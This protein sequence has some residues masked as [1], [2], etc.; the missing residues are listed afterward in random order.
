MVPFL[1]SDNRLEASLD[2]MSSDSASIYIAY[3]LRVYSCILCFDVSGGKK[4][5]WKMESG[6][7]TKSGKKRFA[8]RL[9]VSGKSLAGFG[10]ITKLSG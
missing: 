3:R 7:R 1:S 2:V 5:T 10:C 6:W 4:L 8:R 9:S